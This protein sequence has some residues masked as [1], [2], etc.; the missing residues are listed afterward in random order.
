MASEA[1]KPWGM[2][3]YVSLVDRGRGR[4][5]Y[6][7]LKRALDV[8]VALSLLFLLAPL[9]AL[10]AVLIRLESPGPVILVQK[11]VGKGG[12]VFDFY[13]FRSMRHEGDGGEHRTY[14]KR[15]INGPL[16]GEEPAWMEGRVSQPFKPS[17]AGRITRVGRFLRKTSLDELPQ[18]FNVVKGDM[19]LVGP[20]PPMAYEVEEYKPWHWRRFEVLPGITGLAQINGRSKLTFPEIIRWDFKYIEHCSFLLDLMILLRTIPMVLTGQ[21]AG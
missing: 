11:R 9:L 2:V 13:K 16:E 8:G 12:R 1:T 7:F 10:I 20:R 17:A 5:G 14:I 4:L 19:S 6:R 18:L 3:G 15:Y 21:G